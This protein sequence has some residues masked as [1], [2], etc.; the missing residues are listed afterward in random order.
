MKTGLQKQTVLRTVLDTETRRRRLKQWSSGDS[1][2]QV[3]AWPWALGCAR[4]WCACAPTCTKTSRREGRLTEARGTTWRMAHGTAA[5]RGVVLG[6]SILKKIR[7]QTHGKARH[8]G[9][10]LLR[11]EVTTKVAQY[12]GCSGET[13]TYSAWRLEGALPGIREQ[14]SRDE[15]QR[16][17]T[18]TLGRQCRCGLLSEDGST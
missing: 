13:A 18:L 8:G 11:C 5:H 9:M 16:T 1:G 7:S 3:K 2:S 6:S 15:E 17:A 14:G 4:P 10:G 12:D